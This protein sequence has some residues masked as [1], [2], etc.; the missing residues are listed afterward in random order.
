MTEEPTKYYIP[1]FDPG[2]FLQQVNRRLL[3]IL[4]SYSN[5]SLPQRAILC[6]HVSS[7][8]DA[9]LGVEPEDRMDVIRFGNQIFGRQTA[10]EFIRI[11]QPYGVKNAFC[12]ACGQTLP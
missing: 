8:V 9:M 6:F 2:T 4:K 1:G 3:P 12:N 5:L 7:L 11:H 10:R